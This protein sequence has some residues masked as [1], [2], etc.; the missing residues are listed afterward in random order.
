MS[1]DF[2]LDMIT[3]D[4]VPSADGWFEEDQTSA[5]AVVYQL[6]HH[7]DESVVDPD[8]G[9]RLHLAFELGD[10]DDAARFIEVETARAMGVLE[11]EGYI[12]GVAVAA[13]TS[14]VIGR[15]N[16]RTRYVDNA[17]AQIVDMVVDPYAGV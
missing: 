16:A 3:R 5:A 2:T 8:S 11:Q 4:L 12:S 9:S 14:D 7:L 13:E 15:L 1:R 6:E 17:S 10:T